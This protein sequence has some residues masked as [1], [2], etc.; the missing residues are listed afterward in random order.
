MIGRYQSKREDKEPS[1][2]WNPW[3]GWCM[4]LQSIKLQVPRKTHSEEKDDF[5]FGHND[6]PLIVRDITKAAEKTT[7]NECKT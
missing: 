5:T 1:F 2:V 3:F 7:C 6:I 4:A